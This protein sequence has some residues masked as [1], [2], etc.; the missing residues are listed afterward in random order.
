ML[1]H[2]FASFVIAGTLAEKSTAEFVLL[3]SVEFPFAPLAG[4]IAG[5][6][7]GQHQAGLFQPLENLILP[8]VTA[9]DLF[10]VEEGPEGRPEKASNCSEICSTSLPTWFWVLSPRE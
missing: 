1:F 2:N 5:R 10:G 3:V 7:T 9:A 4:E 6:Q 8:V